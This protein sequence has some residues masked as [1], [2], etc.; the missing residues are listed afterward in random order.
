MKQGVASNPEDVGFLGTAGMVFD[1]NEPA[2]AI[3]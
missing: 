2:D 1:A 3:E